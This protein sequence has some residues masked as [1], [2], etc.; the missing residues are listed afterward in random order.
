MEDLALAI[1]SG[2]SV[3]AWCRRTGTATRTAR[4]WAA[5]PET[6]EKVREI[7][8]R[9][10]DEAIGRLTALVGEAVIGIGKLTRAESESVRLAACRAILSDLLVIKSHAELESRIADLEAAVRTDR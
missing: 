6:K 3:A 10:V 5:L 8:S 4:T 7:R 1:A 2:E 9:M